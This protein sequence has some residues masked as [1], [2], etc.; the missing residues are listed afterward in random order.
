M[1]PA[2]P[3][4]LTLLLDQV[5]RL[6]EHRPAIGVHLRLVGIVAGRVPAVAG[7]HRVYR[8]DLLGCGLSDQPSANYRYTLEAIRAQILAVLDGLSL[9]RVHWVGESSGG[10][11]GL[12]LAA[13]APDRIESL[14][15]C[16]K[17]GSAHV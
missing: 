4:R 15:L 3:G 13:A 2:P 7:S 16:N 1:D 5:L 12:L 11:I 17:I 14:V 8:P 6:E 9:S 10:I